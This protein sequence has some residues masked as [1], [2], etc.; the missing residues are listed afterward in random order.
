MDITKKIEEYRKKKAKI[1]EEKPIVTNGG[2]QNKEHLEKLL[3]TDDTSSIL[4]DDLQHSIEESPNH[5]TLANK[6]YYGLCFL[7]WIVLYVIFI[8]LQFGTVFFIVSCLVGI[9]LNTRTSPKRK[10]EIS[11]YSVFNKDCKSI[12]GTLKAE[13]FEREIRFGP[14]MVR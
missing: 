11:A 8:E 6:L 2:D 5:L 13:Q 9:Y 3:D 12:D 10:G 4:S 1:V 14:G 7:F